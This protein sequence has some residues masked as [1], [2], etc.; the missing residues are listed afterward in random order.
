ML[1]IKFITENLDLVQDGLQKK[2]YTKD[3]LDLNALLSLHKEINKLKTSS[4]SLAEEKNKLSASIKSASAEE[5]PAIIAKSKAL[6]EEFK[7][8]QDELNAK[9]ADF[10]LMML[11]MPNMPSEQSPVGPDD[12]ANV[13]RRKIGQIREFSFTSD[14]SAS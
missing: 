10:D 14:K 2:G 6:G 5:R 8:L 13:V 4:Q 3:V 11:K 7:V 12:S 9:Q 1:D